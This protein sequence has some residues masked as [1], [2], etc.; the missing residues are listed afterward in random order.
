MKAFLTKEG[1][2]PEQAANN[3]FDLSDKDA[4]A[5][6]DRIATLLVKE[7]VPPTLLKVQE[8][9]LETYFLRTISLKEV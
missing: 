5:S 7:N 3:Y 6:P 1:Y 4:I 2:S 9:D 8:E